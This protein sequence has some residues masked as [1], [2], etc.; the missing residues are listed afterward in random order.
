MKIK[1]FVFMSF[2]L[3][4]MIA[5]SAC[6]GAP[7][8]E[9]EYVGEAA[10][11][12]GEPASAMDDFSEAPAEQEVGNS[13]V[14]GSEGNKYSTLPEISPVQGVNADR[15]IIKNAEISI[16]VAD[17]D[18]AIDRLTQ[19]VSDVNGYIISSRVWYETYH[20]ENFKYASVTIGVPVDR[21]ELAMRRT[22]GLAIR[23]QDEN[24]S[25]QDVTEQYVDL[26]SRL[27]NLE[28][29]RDRVQS[30]LDDAK[31]VEEALLINQELA[32]IEAQIEEVKGRLNYMS[33][34]AAFSTITITISPDLPAIEPTPTPAPKAW[35][36]A[37]TLEDATK[38]L[39]RSYQGIVEFAIWLFVAVLPVLAPPAFLIW[40]LIK[41]LRRKPV[42]PMAEE[43]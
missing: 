18:V 35:T 9:A 31:S 2:G 5:L 16:L 38:T 15:L 4:T 26:E 43:S 13:A 1:L 3:I 32:T 40:L 20:K 21:F 23:V 8:K 41:F 37:D 7:A 19:V 11:F 14:V 30:F 12:M 6:G 42:E 17:S 36:P 24:A 25:G 27:T 29:T 34:R 39:V 22:R 28:V 33:D 10:P